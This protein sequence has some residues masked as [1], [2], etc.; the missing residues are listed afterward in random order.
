M[1]GRTR[2]IVDMPYFYV[3]DWEIN[4]FQR[5]YGEFHTV[6]HTY[7]GFA[8]YTQ[9]YKAIWFDQ[10]PQELYSYNGMYNMFYRSRD[11][12]RFVSWAT[13]EISRWD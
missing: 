1:P 6:E 12:N 2:D 13:G 8:S 11:L 10:I 7:Q 4:Q 3:Y 9:T 5:D